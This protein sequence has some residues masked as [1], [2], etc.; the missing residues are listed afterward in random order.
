MTISAPPHLLALYHESE[1]GLGR[2]GPVLRERGW[3]VDAVNLKEHQDPSLILNHYQALLVLGGPM[4]VND[5]SEWLL[6]ELYLIETAIQSRIPLMGV[7]LGAQ[8]IAKILGKNVSPAP[9]PEIGWAPVFPTIE[10]HFDPLFAHLDSPAEVF[11]WHYE[12][13]ELPDGAVRLASSE[14]CSE[15][16]F[17]W[18]NSVYGMQFHL[19][20][21]PAEIAAWR[22]EDLACGEVRE[23]RTGIDPWRNDPNLSR[24]ASRIF[25]AWLAIA[26]TAPGVTGT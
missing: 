5:K 22:D 24:L 19:E 23:L 12:T 15:Q 8:M 20:A 9:E 6:R 4:S 18:G 2:F 11:H 26:E 1:A 21:G 25:G 3:S 13:Y 10:A 14:A 17:R 7:C 16:A